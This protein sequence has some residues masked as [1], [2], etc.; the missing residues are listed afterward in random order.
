MR[1]A[2]A[3]Q[4]FRTVT[5]H[6]GRT[7]RFLVFEARDGMAPREVDRIDLPPDMTIHDFAGGGA[8][9]L[10]AMAAVIVGS[11]GPGFIRRMASRGVTAVTTSQTDPATA[12]A[13][14]LAGTLPPAMPHEHDHDGHGCDGGSC[15]CGGH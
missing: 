5:G 11:A 4:D 13:Q 7:R 12:V 1:I 14:Y 3:S 8:H 10:D 15:G 2:V 9:P 6:A